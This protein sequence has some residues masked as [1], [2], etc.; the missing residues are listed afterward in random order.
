MLQPAGDR[1]KPE[2]APDTTVDPEG[3]WQ[4]AHHPEG[5]PE[6]LQELQEVV[7]SRR[8][9]FA[10]S[11]AEMPGYIHKVGWKMKHNDPIKEPCHSRRKSP[12]EQGILDEKCTELYGA[13]LISEVSTTNPYATHA[14][15]AAK[16]DGVTGEWTEKRLCQDYRR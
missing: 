10:Y 9:A 2:F 7:R 12:A 4:F 5:T 1:D 11:H 13:K 8:H 14:V 15:L 3:K 16:K 6:Q